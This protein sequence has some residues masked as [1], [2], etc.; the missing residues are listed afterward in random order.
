MH[1]DFFKKPEDIIEAEFK[2]HARSNYKIGLPIDPD[3]IK[4]P[5]WVLEAATM[6]Y[7]AWVEGGAVLQHATDAGK[8]DNSE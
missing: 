8:E 7:E 2:A 3:A 1:P 6:N 5:V 4:H